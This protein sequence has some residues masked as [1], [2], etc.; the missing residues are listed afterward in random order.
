LG[1]AVVLPRLA[2]ARKAANER[3]ARRALESLMRAEDEF[4]E[5]DRDGDGNLDYGMLSELA[6]AGLVDAE[7]G[8]GTKSGYLFRATYSF[9][10]SEFL[11]FATAEPEVPTVT[12]DRYFG[13][14]VSG[15]LYY[16]TGGAFVLDTLSCPPPPHG[17]PI[18]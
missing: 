6:K 15:V 12:G 3:T 16:T 18:G 17:I 2:A 14:N 13:C 8:S 5:N 10:T 9:T 11:W 7:L 4:R 1:G